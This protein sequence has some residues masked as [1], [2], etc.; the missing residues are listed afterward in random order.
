[1]RRLAA[2]R[3]SEDERD[4]G[5][6]EEIIGPGAGSGSCAWA[7]RCATRCPRSCASITWPI[8][9]C[10]GKIITV[11]EVRVSPDLRNATAFVMPLGGA[12]TDK[13]VAGAEPRR[14]AISAASSARAVKMQFTP[15]IRFRADET[16]EEA[17]RIEKLLHDP[18]VVRDLATARTRT[19]RTGTMRR[20]KGAARSTAG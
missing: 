15:T 17:S 8:P 11:T 2:D 18:A 3:L 4:H 7:R 5:S 13:T 16:F 10:A 12:E 6:Q 9:T 20:K 1:M 19:R 14:A